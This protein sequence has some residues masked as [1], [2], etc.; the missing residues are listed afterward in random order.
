MPGC[1][2][3]RDDLVDLWL[4]DLWGGG[5]NKERK[6]AQEV[7]FFQSRSRTCGHVVKKDQLLTRG[8]PPACVL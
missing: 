2:V 3:T 6:K 7:L 1:L 4:E 5:L 8:P